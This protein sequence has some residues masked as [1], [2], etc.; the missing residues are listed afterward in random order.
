MNI[1]KI[2]LA[3]FLSVILTACSDS[4]DKNTLYVATSAD[5]PPY[6]HMIHGEIVGFDIDLMTEI[7]KYLKKKIEFKNM[8]F[9]GLIA[10]LASK[11]IDMVISAISITEARMVK[12]DFSIP[13]TNANIAVLFRAE[14]ELQSEEDFKGKII[15]AQLGTIWTIIA[16][17]ISLKQGFE[18]QSLANNLML[19]EELKNKRLDAIILEES[20]IKE[21]IEK[22][23]KLASFSLAQYNSSFAITLPKNSPLKND[24][25]NA[26]LALQKNGTISALSKKWGMLNAE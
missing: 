3:T 6:E 14:D 13:Y 1:Y 2:L 24:I 25:N 11:N 5:N 23:P 16:N 20:Q 15:G 8:E 9:H 18:V 22:N 17:E 7:G 26:I 12:V 21:F 19:V 10:A 4:S